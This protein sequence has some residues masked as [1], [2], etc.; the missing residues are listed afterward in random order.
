[1][2]LLGRFA[3]FSTFLP[4]LVSGFAEPLAALFSFI[5]DI[6]FWLPR[7]P[8][9]AVLLLRRKKL[10]WAASFEPLFWAKVEMS[11]AVR[12]DR[13]RVFRLAEAGW[14]SRF[15]VLRATARVP[16]NLVM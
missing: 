7:L 6:D 16:H 1:M 4:A 10:K 3:A 14:N 2:L 8:S 15:W 13:F 5:F 12:C 9:R 11:D